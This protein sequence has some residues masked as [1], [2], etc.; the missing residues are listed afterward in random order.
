M[1]M[2]R[3]SKDKWKFAT[4]DPNEPSPQK[5]ERG[6]MIVVFCIGLLLVTGGL[7]FAWKT[8]AWDDEYFFGYKIHLTGYPHKTERQ[9]SGLLNM[10]W[11]IGG[12][13]MIAS[14]RHF[15][16]NRTR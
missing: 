14:V 2:I 3:M 13:M 9:M 16:K 10:P 12:L 11:V 5:I 4:P 15:W 6:G 8:G 1:E 7:F